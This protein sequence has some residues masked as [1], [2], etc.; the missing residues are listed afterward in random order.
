MLERTKSR[1]EEERSTRLT[2]L[3]DADARALLAAV[4]EL[5]VAR[6]RSIER[7]PAKRARLA[8][9]RG[10]TGNYRAPLV[11]RGRTLLVGFHPA[12]L[13]RLLAG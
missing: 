8:D 10:P 9:L 2:P 5:L 1:V 12:T 4:D 7:V 13:A 6:G 11:R 3:T